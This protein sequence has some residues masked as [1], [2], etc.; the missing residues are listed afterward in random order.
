MYS[1]SLFPFRKTITQVSQPA[2]LLGDEPN[3]FCEISL[4]SEVHF[5]NLCAYFAKSNID[6]KQDCFFCCMVTLFQ[7]EAGNALEPV[8]LSC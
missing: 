5:S 4:F 3:N 1:V 7:W 8:D 2:Y 6:L